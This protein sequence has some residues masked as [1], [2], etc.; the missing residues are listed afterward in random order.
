MNELGQMQVE[1]ANLI[2]NISN[3]LKKSVINNETSK[4]HEQLMVFLK[5]LSKYPE[6]HQSFIKAGITQVALD[7]IKIMQRL[8]SESLEAQK[9]VQDK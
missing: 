7:Y 3:F 2:T 9:N 1:M 4:S 8:P 5:K 6:V